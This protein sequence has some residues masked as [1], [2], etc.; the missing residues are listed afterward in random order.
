MAWGGT[1]RYREQFRRAA[2]QH[3]IELGFRMDHSDERRTHG[4]ATHSAGRWQNN[5][6]SLIYKDARREIWRP[7]RYLLKTEQK[8]H[9]VDSLP[10]CGTEAS[11]FANSFSVTTLRMRVMKLS[12]RVRPHAHS[13]YGKRYSR[14]SR[15]NAR[16]VSWTLHKFP[17][18]SWRML[19]VTLTRTARSLLAFRPMPHLNGRSCPSVAGELWRRVWKA[20]ATNRTHA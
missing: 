1:R 19:R 8:L 10:A 18:A 15:K 9:G 20:T 12:S 7:V 16:R 3:R 4:C 13:E 11:M 6:S 2:H 5:R 14:Y 17:P